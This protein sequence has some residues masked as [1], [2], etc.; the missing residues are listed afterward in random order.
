MPAAF[1]VN[2]KDRY[3]G[4]RAVDYFRIGGPTLIGFLT[5]VILSNANRLPFDTS[6]MLLGAILVLFIISNAIGFISMLRSTRS[7][8]QRFEDEVFT[9]SGLRVRAGD[10]KL[11]MDIRLDEVMP[12]RVTLTDGNRES[13]WAA[14]I[15]G[16][17]MLFQPTDENSPK[18]N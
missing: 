13:I 12:S 6:L 5:I 14:S 7:I 4:L 10:R 8:Q 2:V 11:R 18:N 15:E 3:K 16:D 9:E 17:R 1:S